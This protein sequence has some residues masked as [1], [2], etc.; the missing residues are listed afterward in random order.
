MHAT[1]IKQLHIREAGEVKD[2]AS[3]PSG[4][5]LTWKFNI[6]NARDVAWAASKAFVW[7]AAKINLPSGKKSLA[8]SVYPV[9]SIKKD[10]WQRSTEMVKAS[11]EHYSKMWFEYPY[12]AAINVA[13]VVGGMEYPGIVFCS[14]SDAG[15]GLWGVTDHEFGHTWFPMIVG[16]NERKYAWMD[17]GFNTFINGFSTRAFNKG[18]FNSYP[19]AAGEMTEYIFHKDADALMTTPDVVQQMNLGVCGL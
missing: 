2:P 12:P 4:K 15:A 14:Y 18:E 5:N 13:G 16:S 8:M 10:G 9:E 3:R 6:Q 7:D 17:E 1:V 19:S 11:I